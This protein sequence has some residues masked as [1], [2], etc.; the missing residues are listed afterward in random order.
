MSASVDWDGKLQLAWGWAHYRGSAGDATFHSH[1]ATQMVFASDLEVSAQMDS[2][3]VRG[4]RL[5]IPSNRS[6]LLEPTK[7]AVDILFVEPT[8]IELEADDDYT[9]L[10]WVAY[11]K[12]AEPKGID[13]R[14]E[15]AMIAVEQGL[16]G[17]VSLARVARA[18]GLSKSAFSKLF[19]SVVGMPLR[20]Y[21][22]WRRLYVAARAI[23]DGA[24]ATTAAYRAGFS[25]SAH[26]SRTMKETFG[27]SPS[28]SLL[29]FKIS[30]T[31]Q[32]EMK[33]LT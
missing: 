29:R 1:Y 3:L 16:T 9:L 25:D 7:E 18:A 30:V 6:H 33:F 19:R 8:L 27:V 17:K 4:H 31:P 5:V 21:V 14:I 28:K 11:L 13:D 24:D 10:D 20:R 15:R 22:L 23:G 26:F 2:A 12:E 32:R